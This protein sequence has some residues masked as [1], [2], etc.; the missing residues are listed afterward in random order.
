M[1][2][3]NSAY[4]TSDKI[5]SEK[6]DN[7]EL[8]QTSP[9]SGEAP[10]LVRAADTDRTPSQKAASEGNESSN[11]CHLSSHVPD[12]QTIRFSDTATVLLD[13][14]D[15]ERLGDERWYLITTKQGKTYAVAHGECGTLLYLHREVLGPLQGRA[16]VDHKNGNTLDCRRENLRIATSA[17]NAANRRKRAGTS[18]RFKGVSSRGPRWLAK[19]NTRYLGTFD[20]QEDAARAY[21]RAA[22]VEFG[23]FARLNFPED[24]A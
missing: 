14:E 12:T 24:A 8:T 20:S 18:S 16:Q 23:E 22:R 11:K 6:L 3:P 2:S 19:I 1:H 13:A 21:D 9:R 15:Y 4:S 5:S 7:A 10:I 17:Q